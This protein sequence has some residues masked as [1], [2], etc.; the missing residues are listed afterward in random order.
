METINP[1]DLIGI[2]E[3]RVQYLDYDEDTWTVWTTLTPARF[4]T[5][6]NDFSVRKIQ[7]RTYSQ[8]DII[9]N[10]DVK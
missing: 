1:S 8:P 6:I 10:I 7:I 3:F 4:D 2:S 9:H 5:V